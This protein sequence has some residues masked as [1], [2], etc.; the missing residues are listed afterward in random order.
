MIRDFLNKFAQDENLDFIVETAHGLNVARD[1]VVSDRNTFG[2]KNCL[3]YNVI[4][5]GS[6]NTISSRKIDVVTN[7]E[8]G[9][10]KRCIKETD[11]DEYYNDIKE[12]K[13]ILIRLFKS[14]NS[15]F[16][17]QSATFDTAVDSLDNNNV[18]IKLNFA[19]VEDIN[20]C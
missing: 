10:L 18:I 8:V 12:L 2:D 17:V 13:Q 20:I 4:E 14:V 7:Y 19:I 3:F 6:I 9:L 5:S 11:G 16:N 1:E 15:K